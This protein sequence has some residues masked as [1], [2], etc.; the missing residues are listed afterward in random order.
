MPTKK[1]I[2]LNKINAIVI[3]VSAGGMETLNRLFSQ[4]KSSLKTPIIIV[5]HISPDQEFDFLME[6]YTSKARR[7]V[8]EVEEKE[9]I[10]LGFIYFAPP[11]YHILVEEDYTFS[12]SVEEKIC[13]SRPSIDILFSSASYVYM[14]HLLGIVLTGAN[15][16]GSDGALCIKENG[17]YVIAQ[18]PKEALYPVMPQMTI[19]KVKV[20]EILTIDKIATLLNELDKQ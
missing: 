4:L 3:G 8:K 7:N 13:Y 16:D 6:H 11:N 20:D 15:G 12:L 1:K 2:K 19:D 10:K 14:S 5:Q 9:I 18:D 17:G